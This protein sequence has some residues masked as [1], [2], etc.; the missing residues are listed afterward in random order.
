MAAPR[1]QSLSHFPISSSPSSSPSKFSSSSPH[2]NTRPDQASQSPKTNTGRE[3]LMRAAFHWL[4]LFSRNPV[5]KESP[6]LPVPGFIRSFSAGDN[7]MSG[8]DRDCQFDNPRAVVKKVLAK[9][10]REGEGATVRRSI[11]R[12]LFFYPFIFPSSAVLS[13]SNFQTFCKSVS[14]VIVIIGISLVFFVVVF[15]SSV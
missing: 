14:W 9:Q 12:F 8:S 1:I 5:I 4:S 13:W 6:K 11:G 7:T 3:L 15:S 10:Q 2:I